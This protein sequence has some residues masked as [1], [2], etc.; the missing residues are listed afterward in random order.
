[1][2]RAASVIIRHNKA[3]VPSTVQMDNGAFLQVEP[4]YIA[5]L[6]IKELTQ[7][8]TQ[9][10]AA[11][12]PV[13]PEP[14]REEFK[15]RRDP[16]LAAT[17][18]RSWKAMARDSLGYGIEWTDAGVWISLPELDKQGRFAASTVSS[19]RIEFPTNTGMGNIAMAILNDAA[20]RLK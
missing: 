6:N 19:P 17:G 10:L 20:D 7:A 14:T 16:L 8:L 4:V 11:D 3:Y 2:L 15:N 5:D 12:A 9:V 13:V 1:M 18:T